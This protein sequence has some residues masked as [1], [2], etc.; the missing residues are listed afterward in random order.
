MRLNKPK[1]L[2]ACDE[3]GKSNKETKVVYFLTGLIDED[4]DLECFF[5]GLSVNTF[6]KDTACVTEH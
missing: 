1:I 3:V 2:I 5:T 6:V 4:D